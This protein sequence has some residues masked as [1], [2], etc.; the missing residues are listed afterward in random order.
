MNILQAPTSTQVRVVIDWLSASP[1]PNPD[2]EHVLSLIATGRLPQNQGE[3]LVI[4]HTSTTLDNLKV[5]DISGAL[6]AGANNWNV[7]LAGG[8]RAT[9]EQLFSLVQARGCPERIAMPYISSEWLRP[10]LIRD[11]QLQREYV[12]QIMVCTEVPPAGQGR[13]ATP[14]DKPQLQASQEADQAERGRSRVQTDWDKLIEQKRVAVLEYEGQVVSVVKR[15]V[16]S[17]CGMIA[18]VFTFAPYRC[19]GFGKALLSFVLCELL[20]EFA[21]VKLWVDDDNFPAIALYESL[22]FRAVGSFYAGYFCN[23]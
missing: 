19:Q 13:W 2:L 15:G 20:K 21:V 3:L 6:M 9:T 7:S 11:Y 12:S 1:Y 4:A 22:G 8:D 10:K 5:E 23:Q 18:G 16:P 14:D 17:S